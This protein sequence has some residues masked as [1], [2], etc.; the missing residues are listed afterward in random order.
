MKAILLKNETVICKTS[1]LIEAFEL[2]NQCDC[3]YIRVTG[4]SIM[5]DNRYT[6]A[7]FEEIVR[8]FCPCELI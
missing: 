5:P 4:S 2:I 7:D 8:E 6:I 1:D 3:N